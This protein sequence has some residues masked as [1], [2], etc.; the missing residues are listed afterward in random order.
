M[1]ATIALSGAFIVLAFLVALADP[2]NAVRQFQDDL[3]AVVVVEIL[4]LFPAISRFIELSKDRTRETTSKEL[5]KTLR[6][7]VR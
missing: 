4:L 5:T 3:Q 6:Q 2:L 7:T 1:N